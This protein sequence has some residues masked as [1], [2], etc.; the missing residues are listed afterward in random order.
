MSKKILIILGASAL[1]MGI[2]LAWYWQRNAYS[3]EYMKLEILAPEAAV[4]GEEITYIVKYKNNSD[5]SLE[6]LV[7]VFDFP[8]GSIAAEGNQKRVT[9]QLG[10]IYP[11]QEQTVEFKGRLFGRQGERKEAKAQL[12]YRPKNISAKYDA[13]TS[14]V[15]V[16]SSSPI[17]LE[18]D[19]PASAENLKEFDFFLT[20]DS[21]SDYPLQDLLIKVEYP[22]GFEIVSTT[23]ASVGSREWNIGLLNNGQGGKIALRGHLQGSL[24]EVKTFKATIGS[25]KDGTFLVL[26]EST[27][28]IEVATPQVLVTQK[29]NGSSDYIA[30]PGDTLH[31]EISFRNLSDQSLENLS[32]VSTLEGRALDFFTLNASQGRAGKGDTSIL[33]DSVPQLKYL[34]P[35]DEGMVEFWIDVKDAWTRVSSREE[36]FVVRNTVLVQNAK[37]R[38]DVKVNTQLDLEQKVLHQDDS[39]E[40]SGPIPPQVGMPTTYTVIWTVANRYNDARNVV[41]KAHLPSEVEPTGKQMPQSAQLSYNSETREVEWHVGD[42]AAG[43]GAQDE[44]PSVAFQIKFIPS[45]AQRGAAPQLIYEAKA[46]GEDAFT[47]RQVSDTALGVP[48]TLPDDASVSEDTGRVQ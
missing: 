33:W 6:Q 32:L 20:Y 45:A 5:F 4:G 14:S 48:S 38:F 25:W 12:Q 18:W 46:E 36:N 37:S 28:A 23:P 13:Q 10:D 39:F 30:S 3:R 34:G 17:R 42:I 15:T 9:K 27:R 40:N 47:S 8:T 41:V 2:V 1:L 44:A 29:V 24:G 11:G 35:G 19:L 31:Y 16:L 7:L 21:S 43:A 22:E 26:N